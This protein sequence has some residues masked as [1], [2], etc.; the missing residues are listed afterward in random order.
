MKDAT[1][2]P[3]KRGAGPY[4]GFIFSTATRDSGAK[5]VAEIYYGGTTR[6]ERDANADLIVCAVNAHDDLVK[7]LEQA[8][9]ELTEI[10]TLEPD[11]WVER[12]DDLAATLDEA[13]ANARR[14]NP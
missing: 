10:T 1:P 3:W 8:S 2:R 4:R 14:P 11:D 7:T 6:E 12:I 5:C 13:I 9:F